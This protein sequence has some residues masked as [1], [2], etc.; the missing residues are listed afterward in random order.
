MRALFTHM[1]ALA[2]TQDRHRTGTDRHRPTQTGT[3]RHRTGTGR[4]RPAQDRHGPARTGTDRH[5][6][7]TT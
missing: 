5:R 3:D 6:I 4:H 2:G 7:G 1:H